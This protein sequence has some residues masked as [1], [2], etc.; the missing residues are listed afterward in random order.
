MAALLTA[1]LLAG[2]ASAAAASSSS[3]VPGAASAPVPAPYRTTYD[4]L[5]QQL[6][7]FSSLTPRT[8]P[9]GSTVVASALESADGNVMRPG[10]LQSNLLSTSTALV[11]QMKAIGET[12]VTI[13]VS[14]PLL[15]PTFPD[16]AEYT[17]FYRS[18]AQVVH[19]EGMTL[20]VEENPLFGNI[21]ALPIASFYAGL[22]L[23]SYAADDQQMAQTII[24]VMHP[25]YL[26]ILN[27]PD[28]Y[29]AV[30]H[31]PGIDLRSAATGVEFVDL[32]LSGLQRDGTMVGAGTGTW[33]DTSYD[34]ALLAQTSIDFL[35]VHLYP[36][37]PVDLTNLKA[38]VAAARAAHKPL[39][40]SECWL[41]KQGVA[42]AP[43][44]GPRAAPNEQKTE[45]FSFWEP[46]DAQFLT[47]VVHYTRS[48]GFLVVSPFATLNF[49]AYQPWTPALEAASSQQVRAVFNQ[50]VRAALATGQLSSVGETYHHL[51]G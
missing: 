12:G 42:G 50:R 44:D 3:V 43:Q 35:D 5:Q 20:T 9:K 26:S 14:F 18:I 15:L 39:V 28:T 10:V 38:Q 21:S 6:R 4:A 13:Q 22:S 24:D 36:I 19:Q 1:A 25:T 51:A 32:V 49:L 11:R 7:A 31:Q 33:M 8:A 29:T 46:L 45:T 37:A 23:P 47:T 30:I 17:T 27:E 16:S 34:Q 40:M 41:Y 48:K 2:S